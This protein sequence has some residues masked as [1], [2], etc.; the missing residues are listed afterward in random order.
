MLTNRWMLGSKLASILLTLAN[1]RCDDIQCDVSV[2]IMA[3]MECDFTGD[4]VDVQLMVRSTYNLILFYIG[5]NKPSVL[6]TWWGLSSDDSAHVLIANHSLKHKVEGSPWQSHN[7]YD[8]HHSLLSILTG[9]LLHEKWMSVLSAS[10]WPGI[11][12]LGALSDSTG[13]G[14]KSLMHNMF[15]TATLLVR[16]K[17]IGRKMLLNID[18]VVPPVW[19]LFVTRDDNIM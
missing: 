4:G 14:K 17:Y 7:D 9:R 8:Y 5:Q 19:P 10:S 6:G 15:L 1:L 2:K 13:S 16:G 11:V 18:R 3:S 12:I